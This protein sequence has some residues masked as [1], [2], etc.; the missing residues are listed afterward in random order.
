MQFASQTALIT[1]MIFHRLNK[2]SKIR[3]G[4]VVNLFT[5]SKLTVSISSNALIFASKS[6]HF[7]NTRINV[8]SFKRIPITFSS[9]FS[10]RSRA[11]ISL[12]VSSSCDSKP[13]IFSRISSSN[14]SG[15]VPTYFCGSI[16]SFSFSLFFSISF[17][18]ESR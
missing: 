12:M 6:L 11:K 4:S 8:E 2:I 3:L 13:V 1:L 17:A 16:L 15:F 14:S 10:Q 5:T 18:V 7:S 9:I